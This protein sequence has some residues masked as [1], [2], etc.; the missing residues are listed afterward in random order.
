M[1]LLWPEKKSFWYYEHNKFLG[2]HFFVCFEWSSIFCMLIAG[3]ILSLLQRTRSLVC[4]CVIE[5]RFAPNYGWWRPLQ[6]WMEVCVIN[7][8]R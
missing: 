3:I 8:G 5:N 7:G 2:F 1:D 6:H 4:L